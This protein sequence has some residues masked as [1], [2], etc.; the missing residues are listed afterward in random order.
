MNVVFYRVHGWCCSAELANIKCTKL[1]T[2]NVLFRMSLDVQQRLT[3]SFGLEVTLTGLSVNS[4]LA[5]RE[6]NS[7][8]NVLRYVAEDMCTFMM[9]VL[10]AAGII[11][12]VMTYIIIS[13]MIIT[14]RDF[15]TV[16]EESVYQYSWAE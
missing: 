14:L 5:G 16:S 2:Q 3:F 11:H 13:F 7:H 10:H 4:F 9:I 12:C 1:C 8:S 15:V 6:T